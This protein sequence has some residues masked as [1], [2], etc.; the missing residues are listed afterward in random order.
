MYFPLGY[1]SISC[2]TESWQGKNK[3]KLYITIN[4]V[5]MLAA[6]CVLLSLYSKNCVLPTTYKFKLIY[7]AI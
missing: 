1:A 7:Q 3:Q 2:N 4:E 5:S 6:C